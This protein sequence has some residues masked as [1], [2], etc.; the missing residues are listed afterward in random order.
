MA[1][2]VSQAR[3]RRECRGRSSSLQSSLLGAVMVLVLSVSMLGIC[4]IA[5]ADAL[6]G[7]LGEYRNGS[8][9]GM[10]SSLLASRNAGREA[11]GGMRGA[12]A[13]QELLQAPE[14]Y[15]PETEEELAASNGGDDDQTEAPAVS[16]L[17]AK[18]QTKVETFAEAAADPTVENISLLADA[19]YD[20]MEKAGAVKETTAV[21]EELGG[22][23]V[24]TGL[25]ST[26]GF[27][28]VRET[29]AA[30]TYSAQVIVVVDAGST[31]TR[32]NLIS[33]DTEWCPRKGRRPFM[34]TLT[35][36]GE[37]K[38]TL[39]M[40][41]AIH[42]FI[43]KH[44]GDKYEATAEQDAELASKVEELRVLAV[45]IITDVL[46]TMEVMMKEK[47]T[48]A[49]Y[50]DAK[51]GAVP[52]FVHSTGGVRD[53]P[54]RLREVF[55]IALKD[56]IMN[57]KGTTGV[58][59]FTTPDLA[60]PISGVDEGVYAWL[61]PNHY[62]GRLERIRRI[63]NQ[64]E[65]YPLRY[66]EI[67]KE[68]DRMVAIVEIG[69]AS[70]Q[71][72][73]PVNPTRINPSFVKI[74]D[75]QQEG[76]LPTTYPRITL[77][78]V[79]F[80]QH[81]LTSASGLILKGFCEEPKN[82]DNGVCKFPCFNPGFKQP[83]T[84]DHLKIGKGE[85]VATGQSKLAPVAA[86]CDG[87][88]DEVRLKG[89]NQ[90][91]CSAAR[92]D[93][94]LPFAERVKI[95]NCNTIEGTGNFEQCVQA[96][97]QFLVNRPMPFPAN[98]E[99]TGF[100]FD[101]PRQIFEF[102]PSEAPV[103]MTGAGMVQPVLLLQKKGLLPQNFEGE[104]DVLKEGATK[105]C[106]VPVVAKGDGFVINFEKEPEP[107]SHFN[108]SNCLHLSYA[109]SII[110]G[111][112]ASSAHP[113]KVMFKMDITEV[114]TGT[115]SDDKPS[116]GWQSGVVLSNV[117]NGRMKIITEGGAL[118]KVAYRR[119]KESAEMGTTDLLEEDEL[120]SAGEEVA[121]EKGGRG[122][123]GEVGKRET[124]KG[125]KTAATAATVAAAA[126]AAAPE[127]ATASWKRQS[128][129]AR[130]RRPLSMGW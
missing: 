84:A 109:A 32:G 18:D 71:F 94:E 42:D 11:G 59:F 82:L 7:W 76:Y 68:Y 1:G 85:V 99:A 106:A 96:I 21:R 26:G 77:L 117:T 78:S 52:V 107:L 53:L 36:W 67:A 5:V 31:A 121:K 112:N 95:Q 92:L 10:V 37:G 51:W 16:V 87:K 40:R 102:V 12:L 28:E 38:K 111:M 86:Y 114:T 103:M 8:D 65:P 128:F 127:T 49:D 124:V 35:H 3:L 61:T 27:G 33:Y 73:F 22:T 19:L 115:K 89:T 91:L 105:G 54:G 15:I 24:S 44:I 81:G 126:A 29:V 47:L 119:N 55:F 6:G 62:M 50:E 34:S 48:G 20:N 45:K 13:T 9:S 25:D 129:K 39:G 23:K 58:E 79:S 100:G 41:K 104:I 118:H 69:G 88:T 97:D 90:L 17:Q 93:P 101:N 80:M 72:V 120:R 125:E 30:C 83:C 123:S 60:K 122:R 130:G 74:T 108:Y 43:T 14:S 98:A 2:K 64:L 116:F 46:Q 63:S 113:P 66:P 56:E 110:S 4:R 75:L 70:A 57:Y